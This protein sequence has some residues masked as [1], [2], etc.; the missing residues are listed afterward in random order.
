MTWFLLLLCVAFL[1]LSISLWSRRGS[2]W[3]LRKVEAQLAKESGK[4]IDTTKRRKL[5]K[6]LYILI[7][8]KPDGNTETIAYKAVDLLQIAFGHGL[9][10]TDEPVHL[11]ALIGSLLNQSRPDMAAAVLDTYRGLLRSLGSAEMASEQLQTVGV[12]ALKA[13]QSFVASKAVQILFTLFEKPERTTD[14]Q[15]IT[16]A[17]GTLRVIG[18]IAISRSDHDFFRELL[19]RLC[20]FLAVK[21]QPAV[22]SHSLIAVFS[23]WMQVIVSKQDEAALM[24]FMDRIQQ[25]VDDQLMGEPVIRGILYEWQDLAGIASLNPNSPIAANI[26]HNMVVLAEKSQ[27]SLLWADMVSAV[28]KIVCLIIEQY[29]IISAFPLLYPLFDSSRQMLADQIRFPVEAAVSDFRQR[30]LA[31]TLKETLSIAEFAARARIMGTTYEVLEEL[32]CCWCNDQ[33]INYKMK[34]A[35]KFFQLLILFWQKHM[36]RQASRQMPTQAELM[37]PLLL[38]S[39]E[40]TRLDFMN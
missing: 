27:D 37:E 8:E 19:A 20:S 13:K 24:Q 25:L 10:R 6:T 35:K 2:Q 23:L 17:L 16:A 28:R 29:G 18:K 30:A 36:G 14:T 22:A 33:K 32:Y 26:I 7:A 31:V 38:S 39:L 11:T 3:K 15:A 5:L 4:S 21:P 34:S 1:L 12:M 9:A 40:L